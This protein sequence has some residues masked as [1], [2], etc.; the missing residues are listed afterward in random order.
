MTR[1][2][3]TVERLQMIETRAMDT[4]QIV[5]AR[6]ADLELPPDYINDIVLAATL[7]TGGPV[8]PY[9]NLT[10]YDDRLAGVLDWTDGVPRI[11]FEIYDPHTRQRFSVAHEIGHFVLHARHRTQCQCTQLAVDREDNEDGE[12][13]LDVEREA[14]AF[15]AAFLLPADIVRADL[16]HFGRCISFLAARYQ[17]SE[18]A[19]RRRIRT[20]ERFNNED[21][22]SIRHTSGLRRPRPTTPR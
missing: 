9:P 3:A 16:A 12:A 1:S 6:L 22:T 5:L 14:D 7:L 20:L 17:V 19:M 11:F 15:A 21:C 8:E 13:V 4:R 2:N 18:A 10:R